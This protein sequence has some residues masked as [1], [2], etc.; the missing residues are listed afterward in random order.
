MGL[1]VD[2][3]VY[4]WMERRLQRASFKRFGIT[5]E[6]A[7]STVTMSE[8]LVGVLRA[9]EEERRAIQ[10]AYVEDI[11]RLCLSCHFRQQLLAYTPNFTPI[12][13]PAACSLV[14]MT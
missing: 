5:D 11:L 1:I 13:K 9:R 14:P 12:S 2:T 6:L 3:D 8:L 4:I 7:I 10:S